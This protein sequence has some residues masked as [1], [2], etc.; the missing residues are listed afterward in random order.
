[1]QPYQWPLSCCYS[2][3]RTHKPYTG[4]DCLFI[5]LQAYWGIYKDPENT[6]NLF[7]QSWARTIKMVKL[8]KPAK[9]AYTLHESAVVLFNLWPVLTAGI[10]ELMADISDTMI[11]GTNLLKTCERIEELE[12]WYMSGTPDM[13]VPDG[14][15]F[16]CTFTNLSVAT[17]RSNQF[18]LHQASNLFESMVAVTCWSILP[19]LLLR[20][21]RASVH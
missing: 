3:D 18:Y 9:W 5:H 1:M 4:R 10:R 6:C 21:Q 16:K 19:W 20:C 8:F 11:T 12:L 17:G 13:V 7:H 2:G 14:V 15:K